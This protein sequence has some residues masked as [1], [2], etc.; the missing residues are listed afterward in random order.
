MMMSQALEHTVTHW[1]PCRQILS[2]PQT[3]ED[4]Q[5]LV[6]L[7]DEL[8]DTVGNEETHPLAR[9]METLGTLIEA[10]ETEHYPMREASGLEVL[11]YLMTEHQLSP[12][13]LSELGSEREI[14]K[15]LAGLLP[16][17][18]SQ[19]KTLGQRFGVPPEV[20]L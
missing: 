8:I 10:Y 6:A 14:S 11:N 9:L 5:Q 19:L 3:T 7:L 13:D 15:I 4:Y 18:V 12:Q 16:L 20:F 17:Q 2:V 1:S